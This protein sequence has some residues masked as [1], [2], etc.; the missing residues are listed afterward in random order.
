MGHA[1]VK[2]SQA[3]LAQKTATLTLD[4]C[5]D[6][7]PMTWDLTGVMSDSKTGLSWRNRVPPVGLEPTL[8][9]F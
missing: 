2:V 7:F 8:D 6:M 5:G 1:D 9:G 3:L 4:S